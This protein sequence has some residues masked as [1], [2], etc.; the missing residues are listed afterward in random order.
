MNEKTRARALWTLAAL[1]TGYSITTV[2]LFFTT[3]AFNLIWFAVSLGI[4]GSFLAAAI[5][6]AFVDPGFGPFA[7]PAAT[8][9]PQLQPAAE[10]RAPEP[11]PR[12]K[13]LATV[14]QRDV[15]YQTRTGRLVRESVSTANG[16]TFQNYYCITAD[17]QIPIRVAEKRLDAVRVQLPRTDLVE[18]MDAAIQKRSTVRPVEPLPTRPDHERKKEGVLRPQRAPEPNRRSDVPPEVI[19]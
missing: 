2:V 12:I 6:L 19:T 10:V 11:A 3:G 16:P 5:W 8:P 18:E 17:E 13:T 7:A 15:L 9:I 14:V 1:V 4:Y